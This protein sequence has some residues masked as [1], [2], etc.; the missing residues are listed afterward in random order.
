[1]KGRAEQSI[2]GAPFT[3]V[4]KPDGTDA[5]V[6]TAFGKGLVFG[7]AGEASKFTVQ[8]KDGHGNNG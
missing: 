4:V 1:M 5:S 2:V 7:T 3:V 6:T 8:A